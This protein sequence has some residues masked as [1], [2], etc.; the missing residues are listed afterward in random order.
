LSALKQRDITLHVLRETALTLKSMKSPRSRIYGEL[1]LF[2]S[3]AWE[4]LLF[5]GTFYIVYKFQQCTVFHLLE[6]S[7]FLQ[8][9]DILHLFVMKS[10]MNIGG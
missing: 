5:E 6:S 1:G 10:K 7:S 3:L 9:L 2:C 8:I 4:C